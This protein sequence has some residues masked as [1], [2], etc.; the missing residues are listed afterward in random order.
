[1]DNSEMD[2]RVVEV[3]PCEFLDS[4]EAV[5]AYLDEAVSS[6][7]AHMLAHCLGQIARAR[8]MADMARKTGLNRQALYKSLSGEFAPRM[9]TFMAVLHALGVEMHISAPTPATN[10]AAL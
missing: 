4:T 3:F 5:A 9:D 1:M 2:C 8:G 6:G 7:D 10:Q